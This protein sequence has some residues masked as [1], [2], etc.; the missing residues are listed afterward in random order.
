MK[1]SVLGDLFETK[2][3]KKYFLLIRRWFAFF[4]IIDTGFCSVCEFA[5]C[6][7]LDRIKRYNFGAKNA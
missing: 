2:K 5:F 1:H 7:K 4:Y 6:N 3:Q